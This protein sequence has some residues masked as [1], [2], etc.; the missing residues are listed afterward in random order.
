MLNR[1]I[2]TVVE[3]QEASADYQNLR[4]DIEG[5]GA[6]QAINYPKLSGPARAGDTVLLN[7]T[8]RLLALGTGGFD[9]VIAILNDPL[10]AGIEE[11]HSGH[12]IKSRYQ[13]HQHS[14]LTL[15]EQEQYAEVWDGHLNGMP[16]VVAQLHSQIAAVAAALSVCGVKSVAF[17]MTDAAALPMALSGLVRKLRHADLIQHTITAGQASGG[18]FETV[19]VH[20]A[21]LASSHICDAEVT[22]VCQGPGNA[23]TGTKVGFSG[24]EQASILDMV[25]RLGGV[26]VAAVR[27]SD[28]DPRSRHRGVSHH[29]RTSL[30]LA[31]A[32]C[33]VALPEGLGFSRLSRRHKKMIVG[34]TQSAL[35]LLKEQG[36][37]VTTMGRSVEQD[38]LFFEAAAAAGFAA[39]RLLSLKKP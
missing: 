14:V 26:P 30:D 37:A 22:I 32:H 25:E 29:T 8:A 20:S 17:I 15:E 23:G 6:R 33:I 3:I 2:G 35:Q 7:E 24:I 36:I 16:V 19:T 27:A 38:P 11:V 21:L 1:I 9:F 34:P 5:Q 13:P 18:D 31:Y 28:A 12:I 10:R 4:V 39:G